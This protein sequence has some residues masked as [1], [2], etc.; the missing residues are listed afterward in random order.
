MIFQRGDLKVQFSGKGLTVEG[1]SIW[2]LTLI[3][4]C[5]HV[6]I[7]TPFSVERDYARYVKICILAVR[8]AIKVI[9]LD[10]LPNQELSVLYGGPTLNYRRQ[11]PLYFHHM[12]LVNMTRDL[13][14]LQLSGLQDEIRPT[15]RT[16]EL[17]G[18]IVLIRRK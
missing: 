17:Q 16:S 7:T 2:Y 11:L 5:S 14:H 1:Q 12:R 8:K 18:E 3:V 10:V 13:A 15:F 4:Y 9:G 6:T